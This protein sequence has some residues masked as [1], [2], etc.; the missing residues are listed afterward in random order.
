VEEEGILSPEEEAEVLQAAEEIRSRTRRPRRYIAESVKGRGGPT[1]RLFTEEQIE[2]MQVDI[3]EQTIAHEQG[4]IDQEGF[5]M[6]IYGYAKAGYPI[7]RIA[8]AWDRDRKQVY[9]VV[10]K[11]EKRTRPSA[12]DVLGS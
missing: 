5:E 4:V 8:D 9:R 1:S 11:V 7:G 2:A 3:V 10:E 6:C 12:S